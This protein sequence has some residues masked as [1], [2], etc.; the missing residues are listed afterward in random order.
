VPASAFAW[1]LSA[2]FGSGL[3]NNNTGA[4]DCADQVGT[5]FYSRGT[6]FGDVVL[7]PLIVPVHQPVLTLKPMQRG[8]CGN[9]LTAEP[10]LRDQLRSPRPDHHQSGG[11]CKRWCFCGLEC[12]VGGEFRNLP[13]LLARPPPTPSSSAIRSC[14]AQPQKAGGVGLFAF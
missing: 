7:T 11:D 2:P 12:W 6:S 8:C 5:N 10:K 1:W 3:R 4:D 9:G 14:A 13:H